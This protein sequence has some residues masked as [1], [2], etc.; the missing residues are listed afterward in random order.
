MTMIPDWTLRGVLITNQT[1]GQI[2]E[3]IKGLKGQNYDEFVLGYEQAL[4]KSYK[5]RFQGIYRN[6]RF[7]IEDCMNIRRSNIIAQIPAGR[8]SKKCPR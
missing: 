5:F 7:G 8:P 2:Q 3:E 1:S 6:L 4:G